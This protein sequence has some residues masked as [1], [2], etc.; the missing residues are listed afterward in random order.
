MN[1]IWSSHML[2]MPEMKVLITIFP[3]I[4]RNSQ[5]NKEINQRTV[6]IQICYNLGIHRFLAHT[7]FSVIVLKCSALKKTGHFKHA[8]YCCLSV[9]LACVQTIF[10][11][12]RSIHFRFSDAAVNGPWLTWFMKLRFHFFGG[13]SFILLSNFKSEASVLFSVSIF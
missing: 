9:Y 8:H 3:E 12:V 7:V 2:L 1:I 5:P 4:W 6:N 11:K 13:F 10:F